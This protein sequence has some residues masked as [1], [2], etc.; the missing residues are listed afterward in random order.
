[1]TTTETRSFHLGDLL[2]VTD[3]HLVSPRHIDGVYDLVDFVTGEAHMT[4]QLARAVDV[5]KPWLL[6]QHSWLADVDVPDVFNSEE[7]VLTWLVGATE[8]YGATHD[9][10]AMP[11]GMYVGREPLAEFREMAPDVEIIAVEVE[12]GDGAR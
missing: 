2:S 5:V 9:V 6:D 10:K 8:K 3:G 1:M 11:L 12:P 4:H 7:Q